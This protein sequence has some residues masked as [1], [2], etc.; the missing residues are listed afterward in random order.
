MCVLGQRA[1]EAPPLR[2][3]VV[4]IL[5]FI[6]VVAKRQQKDGPFDRSAALTSPEPCPCVPVGPKPAERRTPGFP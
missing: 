2:T 4:T 6:V 1:L 3:E 5:T